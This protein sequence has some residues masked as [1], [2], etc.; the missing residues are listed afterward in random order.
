MSISKIQA[1]SMNLADTYAFTG[2]VTGTPSDLVQVA[3]ASG[4]GATT[5]VFNGCFTSTYK[6]YLIFAT[7]NMSA[8]SIVSFR[9]QDSSN[10]ELSS[11]VYYN[12]GNKAN[13]SSSSTGDGAVGSWGDTQITHGQY[14]VDGAE[15]MVQILVGNPFLSTR[16][17]TSYL[18]YYSQDNAGNFRNVI[19][20]TTFDSSSSITGFRFISSAG[21]FN[22]T[23]TFKIYGLK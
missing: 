4:G 5:Q 12:A 16:K 19:M 8:E 23:S 2:T 13:R 6:F 21:N 22:S 3:S 18:Q 10:N 20:G 17:T 1:E 15:P 9:Y 14:I 7:F 11:G